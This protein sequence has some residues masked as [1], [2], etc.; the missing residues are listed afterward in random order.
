MSLTLDALKEKS[1]PKGGPFSVYV[2]GE[3]TYG[4]QEWDQAVDTVLENYETAETEI[5][6]ENTRGRVVAKVL[7]IHDEDDFHTAESLDSS[8]YN[9]YIDGNMNQEGLS[10]LAEA[11]QIAEDMFDGAS[12]CVEIENAKGVVVFRLRH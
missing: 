10:S 4:E 12:D 2:D 11:K 9:I 7:V 1:E 6:I 8:S 3:P 5:T